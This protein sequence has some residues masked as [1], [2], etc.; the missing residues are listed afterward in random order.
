VE[1]EQYIGPWLPEPVLT[2]GPELAPLQTVEQ[3]ESISMVLLERLTPHQ[4]AVFLLHEVFAYS[5]TEIAQL[6]GTS[7]ANCRQL[8]HRARAHIAS[9]RPRFEPSLEAQRRLTER[10]LAACQTGNLKAHT[11]RHWYPGMASTDHPLQAG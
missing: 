10:F 4:R 9:Q 11:E 8:F 2:S 3:R 7:V 5:Y 1:R 6:I